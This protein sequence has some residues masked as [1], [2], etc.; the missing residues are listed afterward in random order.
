MVELKIIFEWF[1][2]RASFAAL[3]ALTAGFVLYWLAD[4]LGNVVVK[5]CG[6]PFA[7]LF[8]LSSAWAAYTA[9]PSSD[10]KLAQKYSLYHV[11]S[12]ADSDTASPTILTIEDFARGYVLTRAVSNEVHDFTA[13]ADAHICEKWRRRGAYRDRICISSSQDLPWSFP[14]AA[15]MFDKIIVRSS[16]V[17]ELGEALA[18]L[19]PFKGNLGIVPEANWARISSP[20]HHP[21]SLFWHCLTPSNSLQLT[22]QNVLHDR[23]VESPISFQTEFFENGNFIYRY[24]LSSIGSNLTSRVFHRLDPSDSPRSDRDGDG[25]KIED[26]IFQYGTDP[27]S[28]DTD[29]D[30]LNDY[31]EIFVYGLNPKNPYSLSDVYCDGIAVKL[32]D[33]DPF[34]FPAGSTNAVLEHVFYSGTTNGAFA[35]PQS[36]DSR[37]VL[38]ISVSGSGYGD[39]LVGENAVPLLAGPTMQRSAPVPYE[40]SLSVPKGVTLSLKKRGDQSIDVALD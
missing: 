36:S 7:V 5:R 27:Y 6:V 21:S 32:G 4:T 24:D 35:Y 13:P 25:I 10:E 38:K 20:I 11:P 16:G 33:V 31:E 17:V 2:L 15:S 29:I 3:S 26:E 8:A 12:E 19:E 9:F 30:G 40:L 14:F 28:R 18:R 1:L 23:L 22:W 34:A 39:L 37:A